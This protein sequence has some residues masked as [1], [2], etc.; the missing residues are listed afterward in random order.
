MAQ[1][2]PNWSRWA[3]AG[4]VHVLLIVDREIPWPHAVK[5]PPWGPQRPSSIPSSTAPPATT[6]AT[7]SAVELTAGD[8]TKRFEGA[9]Q[10]SIRAAPHRSRRRGHRRRSRRRGR[11]DLRRQRVREAVA[12]VIRP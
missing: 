11:F 3:V 9:R 7:G 5:L 4:P 1:D 6:T 2:P 12:R 10:L 8:A